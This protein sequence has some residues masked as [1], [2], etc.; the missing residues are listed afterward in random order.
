MAYSNEFRAK[1]CQNLLNLLNSHQHCDVT[2]TITNNDNQTTFDVN[3]IFLSSISPVFKAMLYGNMEESKQN[4]VVE[5]SDTTPD[6]FQAVVN[7]AYCNDP[8]LTPNNIVAVRHLCDKYQISLLSELCDN[9]FSSC[10]TPEN[11]CS[12]LHASVQN[13]LGSFVIKCKHVIQTKFATMTQA[14]KMIN[15]QGFVEMSLS[16]IQIILQ[17]DTLRVAEEDLWTAVLRW[18]DYQTINYKQNVNY[19]GFDGSAPSKKKQKLDNEKSDG[20]DKRHRL[21][22]LKDVCPYIRFGLMDGKY[23]VKQVRPHNCLTDK[24]VSDILCYIQCNDEP[25]SAFSVKSRISHLLIYEVKSTNK[26][27]NE[28]KIGNNFESLISLDYT[29]GA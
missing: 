17:L 29:I 19:A 11:I 2:F 5:I 1:Q 9:Y 27:L 12:L 14:K 18:A 13:K 15:S 7:H 4:A 10:L 8:K 22:L 3:R 26:F 28:N 24:E 25:C 23:F 20:V 21:N 6:A 16:A